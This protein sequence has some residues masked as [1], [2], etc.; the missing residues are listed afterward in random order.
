MSFNRINHAM[1]CPFF[2]TQI[3]RPS[4]TSTTTPI[5]VDVQK[6]GDWVRKYDA[7]FPRFTRLASNGNF[8]LLKKQIQE[9]TPLLNEGQK[10]ASATSNLPHVTEMINRLAKPRVTEL[11]Q[12]FTDTQAKIAAKPD[13]AKL[14]EKIVE[15]WKKFTLPP[16]ILEN[17]A[18]C[19]RFLFESG[20]IFTLVGYRETTLGP[21][22]GEIK[23]DADGHPMVQVQ[24][25]FVRW[26]T[27]QGRNI[28]YLKLDGDGHP[29][30]KMQGRFVRWQTIASQLYYDPKSENIK[31]KAYPGNLVQVWNYSYPQGLIPMD[32]FNYER[33]FDIYQLTQG[34]YDRTK[35]HALKFYE[36][37]PEKDRGIPK[38]CIVQ[39][40]TA[41]RQQ[42]HKNP[43]L[44]NANDQYPLHIGMRLITA[45]RKVYS[46]GVN[47]PPEAVSFIF[48][49]LSSNFLT[50]AD[51]KITMLDYD[52]FRPHTKVVTSILLTAQRSQ[53]IIN[54]I[55]E[56]NGKQFRFN[57]SRQNC[58]T[59]ILEVLKR[60]CYDLDLRTTALNYVYDAL[61]SFNQLPLI[62]PLIAQVE[63][64]VKRIWEAM[65][66]L[67]T[68]PIVWTK[69]VVFYIPKKLLTI[70]VNLLMWKLGAAKKMTPL[71]EGVADEEFYDKRGIQTF[72]SVIRHWTDIFKDET[73]AVYHARYFLDW[74]RQQKSTF[75]DPNRGRP[76]LS[77]VPPAA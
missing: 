1:R 37:N 15:K 65:P 3:S 33:A 17:H 13:V 31:S 55:N 38:D 35:L 30:I 10:I 57:Y 41:P 4:N 53:N 11:R 27:A 34:Q 73:S 8:S 69:D 47:M 7:E 25:R 51:A 29:M 46:F 64:C 36:T 2:S 50:T 67:F 63:R 40:M 24:G 16:S 48:S 77:I 61:P 56:L 58:T 52:E 39:F 28:D 12:A 45:D 32:R 74:Q 72:S 44:K 6:V 18:D 70:G 20:L 14:D 60:A 66:K 54:F 9:I 75:I 43:L 68:D 76:I 71:Q 26:E 22:R 19:A 5:M 23:L 49:D 59:T 62:G 21:D 42:L